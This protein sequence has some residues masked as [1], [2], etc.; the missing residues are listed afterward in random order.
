MNCLKPALASSLDKS[1]PTVQQ[2]AHGNL[3]APS[4]TPLI[5]NGCDYI[6]SAYPSFPYL[7]CI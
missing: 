1:S 2:P 3:S 7:G 5:G 4:R 6:A